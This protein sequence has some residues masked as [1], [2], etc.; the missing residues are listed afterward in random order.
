VVAEE[1]DTLEESEATSDDAA[2][3]VA[4]DCSGAGV[5]DIDS[6]ASVDAARSAVGDSIFRES[7]SLF[8]AGTIHTLLTGHLG[9]NVP[10]KNTTVC[11][12]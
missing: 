4:D 9:S 10:P 7:L 2:A 12:S 3:A 1:P 6:E 11:E 5:A 8:E